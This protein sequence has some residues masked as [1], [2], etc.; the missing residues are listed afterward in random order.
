MYSLD[1]DHKTWQAETRVSL[2]VKRCD[3][4]NRFLILSV[5][6]KNF[7]SVPEICLLLLVRTD[8]ISYSVYFYYPKTILSYVNFDIC[9]YGPSKKHIL[10]QVFQT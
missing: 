4:I 8:D 9:Y 5:F 3:I 2:N 6:K 7:H 10:L 1:A